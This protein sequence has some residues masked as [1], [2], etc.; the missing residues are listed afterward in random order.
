MQQLC[1]VL[2]PAHCADQNLC[3]VVRGRV[4]LAHADTQTLADTY[5][6]PHNSFMGLQVLEL[7]DG[8]CCLMR[9]KAKPR[10]WTDAI[11]KVAKAFSPELREDA[12]A[13]AEASLSMKQQ[14][15][16]ACPL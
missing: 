11:V 8:A 10:A 14:L 13:S 5:I 2:P 15:M 1:A 12:A 4:Q 3:A 9:A 7:F 16:F 6:H